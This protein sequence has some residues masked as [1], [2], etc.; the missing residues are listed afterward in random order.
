MIEGTIMEGHTAAAG[1]GALPVQTTPDKDLGPGLG[2]GAEEGRYRD[3]TTG[4]ETGIGR[5]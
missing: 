4:D 1:V 2:L 5:L 3:L